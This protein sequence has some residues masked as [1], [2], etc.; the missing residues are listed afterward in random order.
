MSFSSASCDSNLAVSYRKLSI[1]H[2]Y[3]EIVQSGF[4][5]LSA[6]VGFGREGLPQFVE[7]GQPA[8]LSPDLGSRG[9]CGRTCLHLTALK[10]VLRLAA[11]DPQRY[12][13]M[14]RSLQCFSL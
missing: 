1:Q 6:L 10:R 13:C 7:L 4:C 14:D 12:G 5:R 9:G 11:P 3:E 2:I 8:R